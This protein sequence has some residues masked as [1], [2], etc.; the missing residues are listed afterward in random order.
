MIRRHPPETLPCV[1]PCRA[2]RSRASDRPQSDSRPT[3]P[4]ALCEALRPCRAD[5]GEAR[6]GRGE[7]PRPRQRA[8]RRQCLGQCRRSGDYSSVDPDRSE[9]GFR[10]PQ[11]LQA[12]PWDRTPGASCACHGAAGRER[13]RRH[14]VTE[15]ARRPAT[16]AGTIPVEPGPRHP[17]ITWESR[18]AR[19]PRA[20]PRAPP[21]PGRAPPSRRSHGP[22]NAGAIAAS[23]TR[24]RRRQWK[25]RLT[26]T[27]MSSMLYA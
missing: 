3:S 19:E 5:A 10:R 16:A 9:T 14:C 25:A 12:T 17:S 27:G 20:T 1:R 15:H 6:P 18:L 2:S 22:A 4:Q 8:V 21:Q 24:S 11:A 7:K 13:M 26:S 23:T